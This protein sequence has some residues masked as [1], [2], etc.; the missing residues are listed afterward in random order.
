MNT[1]KTWMEGKRLSPEQERT[2]QWNALFQG[3]SFLHDAG[4]LHPEYIRQERELR[5][6]IGQQFIQ[7]RLTFDQAN[8]QH[9]QQRDALRAQ[10]GNTPQPAYQH[11]AQASPNVVSDDDD[12][13]YGSMDTP[14]DKKILAQ[15]V[16][17]L[18]PANQFGMTVES[19]LRYLEG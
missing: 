16:R 12:D 4:K 14:V 7:G 9:N 18:I 15:Q 8:T 13:F 10:Y 11:P 1:F 3:T 17:R 2:R 5:N 6:N 19:L